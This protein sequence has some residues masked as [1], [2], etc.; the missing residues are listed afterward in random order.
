[1]SIGHTPCHRPSRQEL[2]CEGQ[3]LNQEVSLVLETVEKGAGQKYQFIGPHCGQM[4][5]VISPE[6]SY[7]SEGAQE[8]S[9]AENI[10]LLWS[11]TLFKVSF[12]KHLVPTGP[13]EFI[14]SHTNAD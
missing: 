13:T 9:N 1:M 11:C 14:W 12:Y 8:N 10:A 7:S 5:I 6:N 3:A 2:R 4:F